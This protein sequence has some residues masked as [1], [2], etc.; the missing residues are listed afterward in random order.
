MLLFFEEYHAQKFDACNIGK[1]M[2]EHLPA[3]QVD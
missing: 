3:N 2:M 1:H